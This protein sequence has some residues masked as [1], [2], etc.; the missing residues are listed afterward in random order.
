M[1]HK[2]RHE[3]DY[4]PM[5]DKARFEDLKIGIARDG[6]TFPI[7]RFKGQILDGRNRLRACQELGIEPKFIDLP[8]SEDPM[9]Y[10]WNANGR[11]RDLSEERRA[12]IW[13]A[14]VKDSPSL[15][16][17]RDE[18]RAKAN[19]KR[20]SALKGNKNASATFVCGCGEEFS[21]KVWHCSGCGHHWPENR[22]D[23]SNCHEARKTV[24]GQNGPLLS[25]RHEG[26]KAKAAMS[27]L[28]ASAIARAEAL[29]RARPDLAAKVVSG[30]LKPA[31][32][33]RQMKRESVAAKVQDL[34]SG[35]FTVIY[36]DPP[37][38]YNDKQGGTISES[39]GAAEKHYPSMSLEE[40]KALGV[41]GLS[42]PDCVLFLWSTCPLLEQAL[43]LA[44]AW[45]FKYKAQFVW[46]KIKHNMGHYNSVRHEL[47]L[48]CTRGSAVPEK[49]KLFDSVQSIERKAHSAKPEE[50]REIIETLYPSGR[51]VELFRR[52]AA[53]KGWSVWGNE[54]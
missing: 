6:Q 47:L 49:A 52:G 23:C 30:E 8:D 17:T 18:I 44:R 54:A 41:P 51:K 35:R 3:A 24:V 32:A 36:A 19:Q 28:N 45:G 25:D 50:F 10:V 46:D 39:Y 14:M 38:D 22:T 26:K 53:P 21:S 33:R 43:E 1:Q 5:M 48:I 15:A 27:G 12:Q 2:I 20:S 11:R 7:S 31:D 4:F 29:D 16:A 13:V 40:L 9:S 42:A 37:W 34:P